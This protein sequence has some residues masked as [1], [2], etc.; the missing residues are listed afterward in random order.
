MLGS[1]ILS[2]ILSRP[3]M[4]DNALLPMEGTAEL[5]AELRRTNAQ[6][7]GRI[8]MSC[9]LRWQRSDVDEGDH[10]RCSCGAEYQLL[11]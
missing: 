5:L 2:R 11:V 6:A 9:G 7:P 10:W 3:L 1:K 8:C 4:L